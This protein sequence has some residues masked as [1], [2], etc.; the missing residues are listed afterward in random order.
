QC[1]N[2]AAAN[3]VNRATPPRG[4]DD[5]IE[6]ALGCLRSAGAR[7]GMSV[8]F[9]ELSSQ[10]LDAVVRIRLCAH[11]RLVHGRV[12]PAFERLAGLGGGPR[13]GGGRA[14]AVTRFLLRGGRVAEPEVALL[15]AEAVA[16]P[17]TL[18]TRRLTTRR[19]PS[20]SGSSVRSTTPWRLR[21][22]LAFF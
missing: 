18:G 8:Q 11:R 3:A 14:R 7:L 9:Q 4:Q 12:D 13:G 22:G 6:D 19:M 2:V 21:R 16:Q 17:E 5:L 10:R 1:D 15:A 20:P